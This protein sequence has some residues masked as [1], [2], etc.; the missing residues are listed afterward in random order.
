MTQTLA[1]RRVLLTG[2]SR[3]IGAACASALAAA[4]AIVLGAA[5]DAQALAAAMDVLPG[6]GHAAIPLDVA[7]PVAWDAALP[8][9]DAGGELHGLVH[10]AG[11]LG[12]IGTVDAVDP[13]AF[14]ATL[15]VNVEGTFL[16]LHHCVP[17]LARGGAV[18]TF[19]GGGAT[20]PLLH[21]DAYAASKA[22]V[23]RLTE[24]VAGAVAARDVTVN[25]IAPGFVATSMH[26]G[27]L[28]AGPEAAGADYFARTQRDL[29]D[30]GVPPEL[31]GELVCFLLGP[32]ARG[33]TGKLLSAQWD[34]WR[35]PAFVARLAAEPTLA[36]LRR[37]D[38]QFFSA[39][40]S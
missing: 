5:R 33:I 2:A 12:P 24:N 11:M 14:R 21:Y 30:G 20:A 32:D 34:P 6:P 27:T 39:T 16:A 18:V 38:D 4:G 19:S 37:I 8:A 15:A 29:Q 35:D 10:A 28:A 31:A 26:E 13:G 1:G 3:G 7:D 40:P 25:A 22:A 36:T 17:R 9:L 23:V